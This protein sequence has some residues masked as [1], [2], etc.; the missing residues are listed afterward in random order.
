MTKVYFLSVTTPRSKFTKA[1]SHQVTGSNH[2]IHLFVI[3]P[4]LACVLMLRRDLFS[5]SSTEKIGM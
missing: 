5:D 1:R 3:K 2:I 4:K